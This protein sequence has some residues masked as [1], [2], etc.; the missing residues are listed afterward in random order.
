MQKVLYILGQLSDTDVDWMIQQ[1]ERQQLE[2]GEVLIEQGQDVDYVFMLLEGEC[3]VVSNGVQ[4]NR[5]QSGEIM[6]EMSFVDTRPPGATIR[7]SVESTVL[8]IPRQALIE[9]LDEDME[10]SA[11]FY[12]AIAIY[13]SYR[14]RAANIQLD[15]NY[16]PDN[17]DLE[18]ELDDNVMDNAYM[19]GARY[20]RLLEQVIEG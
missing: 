9:K 19:A 17:S 11:R 4:V 10:F 16:S 6:G 20:K 13:L 5:L 14:L 3:S 12:K 7:T 1:G 2:S 18:D 15:P 8:A